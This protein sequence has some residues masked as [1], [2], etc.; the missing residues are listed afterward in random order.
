MTGRGSRSISLPSLSVGAVQ[1]AARTA[2]AYASVR[3]QFSLPIGRF[4]GIEE[5]LVWRGHRGRVD[6]LVSRLRKDHDWHV[7]EA[8]LRAP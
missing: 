4:E 5:A 2:G 3:E 6:S 1:L 8:L 7:D